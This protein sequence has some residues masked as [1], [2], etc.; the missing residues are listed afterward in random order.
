M[1]KQKTIQISEQTYALLQAYKASIET[2][3][4]KSVAF[5]RA[6]HQL[7]EERHGLDYQLESERVKVEHYLSYLVEDIRKKIQIS[8]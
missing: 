6:V 3:A 8:R 7:C 4:G 5:D 1:K 2:R